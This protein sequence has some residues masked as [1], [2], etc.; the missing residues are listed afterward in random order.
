M[1]FRTKLTSLATLTL[2]AAASLPAAAFPL[3]GKKK[4]TDQQEVRK[5]TPA[6]SALVDKAIAREKVVIENLKKRTP[7]VETYIQNMRPDPVMGA[8]VDS[9]THFLG[10]VDFGRVINDKSY[11]EEKRGPNGSVG[12]KES[13]MSRFKNSLGYITHLSTSL[14]LTYHESGFVQMLLVDSN[15]FTRQMYTFSYLRAEFLGSIPTAIFDVQP[16]KKGSTGRFA[17]RIWVDRNS[18]NIVRFNGSFSGGQSDI[19]EYYHFDSWRSNVQEGLWLP[20]AFY[21]EE[22]DPKSAAHVLKFKAINYIWGYSL[23]VPTGDATEADASF[24]TDAQTT[25]TAEDLSPLAAGRKWVEQAEDNVIDRLFTAGLIDAPSDYDKVLSGMANNI[26][27][28]NKIPIDRPLKVRTLMTEPLESLAIGNTILLSKSLI[29]TTGI[30]AADGT[31]TPQIGDTYALLAYQVAHVIL[32][33]HID[34]KYAFSDRLLF[35]SE[36]AFQRLPMYHTDKDDEEAAKK[37]M[38]L[39][40]APD[41]ASGEPYF[42][43][44]L[45]Q[46][47]VRAKGLK[48]LN[49]P[50]IGDGL[51]KPDGTFWMQAIISKG[52]K[53]NPADLTQQAALPL[54]SFLKFDSWTDQVIALNITAITPLLS[55]R[56][57]YPFEILPIYYKLSEYKAPAPPA[58]PADAAPATP[59]PAAD[60]TPAAAAAPPPDGT[61]APAT[62]AAP[63]DATAAPAAAPADATAAPAAAPADATAPAAAPADAATAPATAPTDAAAPATAT[64]PPA[65]ATAPAAPTTGTS[66]PPQQ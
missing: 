58:P 61:A 17:G 39:L 6:Q 60:A 59:A 48:A 26:L 15:S 43:L 53:L 57:K 24:G 5:L 30:Y 33:H 16:A 31:N 38:E 41:L 49:E 23:K 21:V 13:T 40:S 29:D 52:P 27:A 56:D 47:A 7:L 66:N 63:A 44:Y 45:Q 19:T 12:G 65:D 4:P 35:P 54:G 22:T 51:L 25:G 9:D 3:M 1:I 14:H 37:A 2:F 42:S 8:T 18:G 64:P 28:Y 11:S 46:L 50:Q 62:T 32:G 55:P 34:T 36:S 10:R 20:N